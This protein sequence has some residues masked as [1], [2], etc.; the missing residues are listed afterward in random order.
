M[1]DAKPNPCT[2]PKTKLT[3][4]R[5]DGASRRRRFSR[6]T[7]T[8]D[9]AIAGSMIRP[10]MVTTP[11]TARASVM[12]WATVKAVMILSSERN[13]PPRSSSASRKS[14]WS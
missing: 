11:R 14:K 5:W 10:G 9:A 2:S 8:M 3:S 1:A 12:L 6:A 13:R 7:Q 4:Q